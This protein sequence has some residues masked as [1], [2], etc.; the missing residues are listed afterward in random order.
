MS[1]FL[2]GMFSNLDC[3]N[4]IKNFFLFVIRTAIQELENTSSQDDASRLG[5][6]AFIQY[7]GS[8]G[9]YSNIK[10]LN[11]S[12][13]VMLKNQ[14]YERQEWQKQR[15][16]SLQGTIGEEIRIGCQMIDG[17]AYKKAIQISVSTSP[18]AKPG[19]F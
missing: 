19:G 16:W 3:G 10:D 8:M 2:L 12:T 9:E 14:V 4:L 17:T 5:P 15:L 1:T 13:V 18:T 6:K 7:P 11:L